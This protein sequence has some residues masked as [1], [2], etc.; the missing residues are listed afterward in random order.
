MHSTV[1]ITIIITSLSYK[2]SDIDKSF[3]SDKIILLK[4][5]FL[6]L[7][8]SWTKLNTSALPDFPTKLKSVL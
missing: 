3:L 8:S 1:G 7:V 5:L 6:A 4:N 2:S